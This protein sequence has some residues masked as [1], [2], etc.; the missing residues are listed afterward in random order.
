VQTN[1]ARVLRAL[2]AGAREL[3]ADDVRWTC[4]AE[5]FRFATTADL[6]GPDAMIGQARAEAALDFGVDIQ[7]KGFNIY[8]VG[9]PGTG[10]TSMILAR[11]RAT[12]AAQPSPPDWCYVFNFDQPHQPRALRLAPG[13]ARRFGRQM[14]DLVET[15]RGDLQR[16]FEAEEYETQ[17]NQIAQSV[18]DLRRA[19]FAELEARAAAAGFAVIHSPAGLTM[20]PILDGEPAPPDKI[21]RLP[22]DRLAELDRA[23]NALEEDL[24]RVLRGLRAREKTA[25]DRLRELARTVARSAVHPPLEDLREE[26]AANPSAVAYFNAVEEFAVANYEALRGDEAPEAS[27]GPP[28]PRADPLLPYQVNIV[29][30]H[31]D[32]QGAPLV[33][34][35]H[36][37]YPNLVGRVEHRSEMG[38]LVTDFTLIKGGA[39]HRANGGYLLIDA[40][41]LVRNG[42]AYAALK[43]ALRDGVIRIDSPAEELGIVTPVLLDPEPIPLDIKV[44]MVGSP[45]VYYLLSDYDADFAELFKV[46]AEFDTE[47]ELNEANMT[48]YAR[49]IAARCREEGL[50]PFDATAVAR[51]A[52]EGVRLAENRSKLSTRFGDISDLIRE[53]EY[54]ARRAQGPVVTA[55]HVDAAAEARVRRANLVETRLRERITDGTLRI[56]LD[57]AVIGQVNGLAIVSVGGYE[58]GHV[59]RVTARTF[60]GR[61]GV[62]HVDREAK[63]TGPIHDKGSLILAGYLSGVFGLEG[64]LTLG[65]SVV[66]EQSYGHVEGDSAS[67]TEL[68]AIL[69]SLS[70]LPIRQD[71]A[72]TG[73]VDQW[74]NI[75]AVGGVTCKI[76]GFFDLCKG[77]GLTG[78]QGVLIPAANVKNLSL[79]RDVAEAIRQGLFHVY[80]VATVAAGLELLADRP[81]GIPNVNG[82]YPSDTVFGAAQTRLRAFARRWHDGPNHN[83]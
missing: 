58:F 9:E 28:R 80:A 51:V 8:A 56:G 29:V 22:A 75:Q 82:E 62:T 10:R 70:D 35:S 24:A 78:V 63:M 47:I 68:Y 61:D 21:G 81:A 49:F 76:E 2:S 59:N 19:A 73:S 42:L 27:D 15:L 67:S 40:D 79:R 13:T 16:T 52:E 37:T 57:G 17:R 6:E 23:R 41:D 46:R 32:G 5:Q 12:A 18:Q 26:Y 53:A 74:G 71:V 20:T 14:E 66:F 77:I 3:S 4:D 83:R 50:L 33:Q 39:L 45:F 36:P 7:S 54:W 25:R 64:P 34:Q 55:E 72:V 65:A 44:A 1:F 30:T 48:R 60:P 69:S 43:R 31:E 38:T 11:L